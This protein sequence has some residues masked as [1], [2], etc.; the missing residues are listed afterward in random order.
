MSR[1]PRRTATTTH[2][3]LVNILVEVEAQT[4]VKL[5]HAPIRILCAPQLQLPEWKELQLFFTW[6]QRLRGF[7]TEK[8]F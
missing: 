1:K 3:H 6:L 8:E 7:D 2:T 4:R 5:A